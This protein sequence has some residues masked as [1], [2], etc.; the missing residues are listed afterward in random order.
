M[1]DRYEYN[2]R[3]IAILAVFVVVVFITGIIVVSVTTGGST[4]TVPPVGSNTSLVYIPGP[5]GPPGAQ[6]PAGP[7]G[8]AQPGPPGPVGQKG[9]PGMCIASP[10]CGVGP[11]GIQG[12]KGDKGDKGDRGFQG[13]TGSEGPIGPRGLNG[14]KGDQGEIGPEGPI[15]PQGEQGICECFNISAIEFETV[16]INQGLHLNGTFTCE[17]GSTIDPTCLSVSTCPN[18][19]TCDLEALTISLSNGIFV[20]PNAN[21]IFGS[22]GAN[23]MNEFRSHAIGTTIQSHGANMDITA[24]NNAA[25]NI[26]ALGGSGTMELTANQITTTATDFIEESAANRHTVIVGSS[27]S[28]KLP[29]GYFMNGQQISSKSNRIVM[30]KASLPP[31][32]S[33][34]GLNWMETLFST[35]DC[36]TGAPLPNR[37]SMKYYEDIVLDEGRTIVYGGFSGF[38]SIGPSAEICSGRLRASGGIMLSLESTLTNSLPGEPL[39]IDDPDGLDMKNTT[40]TS[41][42]GTLNI[43]DSIFTSGGTIDSSIVYVPNNVS[44]WVATAPSTLAEAIDRLAAAFESLHG[45]IP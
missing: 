12:E 3:G 34:G 35:V 30:T 15:G 24:F 8:P 26:G 31:I 40:I 43:M 23:K 38:L 16:D 6:G 32:P 45:A 20:G 41:S 28:I 27:S 14:T 18:F 4:E 33:P 2:Y 22:S 13:L 39:C 7:V 17:A 11:Q 29:T 25:V 5:Q 10:D 44:H 37:A 19:A 42:E 36:P 9:D 21:A 1:N